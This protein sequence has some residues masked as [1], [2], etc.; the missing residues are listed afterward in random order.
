MKLRGRIVLL[1]SNTFVPTGWS[2]NKQTSVSLSSTEAERT[3]SDDALRFEEIPALNLWDMVIDVLELPGGS[4]PMTDKSQKRKSLMA[5]KKITDSVGFVPPNAHISFH[6]KDNDAVIKLII[7]GRSPAMRHVSWTHRV[8]LDWLLDR[9][10]VD[11]GIQIIYVNI[12][13]QTAD[14]YS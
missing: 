9:I 7:K 13:K 11:P 6:F 12:S 2:C 4:N 14:V 1:G 8:D 5:E 3:S 10:N